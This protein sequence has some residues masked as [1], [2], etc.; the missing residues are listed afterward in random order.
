M[1]RFGDWVPPDPGS[2]F[3]INREGE[4]IVLRFEGRKEKLSIRRK[5]LG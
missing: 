4:E 1:E 5:F 2:T 3:R